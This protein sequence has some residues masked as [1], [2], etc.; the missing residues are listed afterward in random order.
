MVRSG[1][2]GEGLVLGRATTVCRLGVTVK[3]LVKVDEFLPSCQCVRRVPL[4]S[5]VV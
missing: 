4:D 1:G 2:S 3:V 5:Y